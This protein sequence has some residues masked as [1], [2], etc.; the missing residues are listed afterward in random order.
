MTRPCLVALLT[1]L[2]I[3][4]TPPAFG[5]QPDAPLKGLTALGVVVEGLGSD[6]KSVV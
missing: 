6:R 4:V 5:Q 3:A 1:I 2:S